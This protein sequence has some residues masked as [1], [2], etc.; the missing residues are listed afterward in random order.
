LGYEIIATDYSSDMLA[1]ARR[2][3]EPARSKTDF[4]RQDMRRLDVPERPFDAVVCLFDAIGYVVTNEALMDVLRGVH[5]HLRSDGLFVFEFWHAAA[6]LRQYEPVRIRRWTTPEGEVLRISETTLDCARQIASVRYTVCELRR[7][8]SYSQFQETQEN[9]YFL[10]QE[11]AGWLENG[12]FKP[13]KWFA[14]FSDDKAITEAT[15]H[16]VAVAQRI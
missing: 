1:C 14:G 8:G 11:M 9:R 6:M 5:R 3:A 12:G 7:D 16:V 10:V 2:K 4:R 15:W 13:V